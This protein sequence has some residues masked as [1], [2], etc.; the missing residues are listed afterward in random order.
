L[1]SNAPASAVVVMDR[2][3]NGLPTRCHV[4]RPGT[5]SNAGGVV[6]KTVGDAIYDA[7]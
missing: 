2:T 7:G 3:C 6:F 4:S 1:T 5:V